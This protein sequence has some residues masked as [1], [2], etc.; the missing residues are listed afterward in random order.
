MGCCTGINK[1][2]KANK[3]VIITAKGLK[4]MEDFYNIKEP[5]IDYQLNQKM[6]KEEINKEKS[7]ITDIHIDKRQKKDDIKKDNN[8]GVYTPSYIESEKN[9]RNILKINK[10]KMIEKGN[11]RIQNTMKKLKL[12]SLKEIDNN[13]KAL[14]MFLIIIQIM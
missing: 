6:D 4:I 5:N 10:N 1:S 12:F 11:H 13:K 9:K 8:N 7:A 2:I 3:D 14:I